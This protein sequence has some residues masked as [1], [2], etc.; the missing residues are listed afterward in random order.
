MKNKLFAAFLLTIVMLVGIS[1]VSAAKFEIEYVE[2]D[3]IVAVEN[4]DSIFVERGQ[5]SVVE[6]FIEGN[7]S[8]DDVRVKAY[9]G[10]YEYDDIEALSNIFEV[11]AGVDYRKVLKFS[12][13]KNLET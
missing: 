12:I 3:D 6:V 4:G 8:S 2:V 7:G 11:E 13:P 10:G 5:D 9:I 1:T